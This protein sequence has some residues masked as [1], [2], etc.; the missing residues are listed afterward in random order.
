MKYLNP[1]VIVA[2]LVALSSG[3]AGCD[4]ELASTPKGDAAAER[5]STLPPPDA[6]LL[7]DGQVDEGR[8]PPPPDAAVEAPPAV[9]WV[10]VTLDPRRA[11][12]TRTDQPE[13]SAQAF[14]RTGQPLQV[15]LTWHEAPPG[16]AAVVDGTLQLLQEGQGV[17]Q[18]CAGEVCGQAAFFVDDAPPV[19]VVDSPIQ[20]EVQ[21]GF[22][23]RTI[24]VRGLATDTRGPVAVRVNGLRADVDAEGHFSLDLPADFGLN[25][26][27]IEAD[28]GV[29]SPAV[30]EVR[31]VMWAPRFLPVE[32]DGVAVP[33]A[34]TL[35][36][37]QALLDRDA[38]LDVPEEAGPV[39]LDEVA[40]FLGLLVGLVDGTVL[41]PNPQIANSP[42]FS[43][44]VDAIRLGRPVIDAGF[45]SDGIELFI[46]LPDLT[47]ETRGNIAFE[48]QRFSLDGQITASMAA[49]AHMTVRLEGGALRAEVE[50]VGVTVEGIRGDFDD[51]TAEALVSVLGNQFGAVARDLVTGLV[52]DVVRDS[53]PQ[54][55]QTALGGILGS[56]REVPL[57]IDPRIEGVPP[58]R[59]VLAMEAVNLELARRLA[60]RLTLDA[61]IR[62]AQ[63]AMAL[64]PDPGVPVL[65]ADEE[66][67]IGADGLGVTVRL[68]LVNALLHEVWRGGTLTLRVPVPDNLARLAGETHADALLPPVIVPAPPG[69]PEPL[70]VQFGAMELTMQPDGLSEPHVFQVSLSA[71]LA[72][73]LVDGRFQL[74][75][76][77]VPTVEAVLVHRG[78]GREPT[79]GSDALALVLRTV[80]WPQI[81]GALQGGLD[82]G[83][84]ATSVDVGEFAR[85]APRVQGLTIAPAFAEVPVVRSGRLRLA[86]GLEVTVDLG[87]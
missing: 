47:L 7:P 64:H 86:G 21:S 56:L 34:L 46:G 24:A 19:L 59:L 32:G 78:D 75:V 63:P 61:T 77:E 44:R 6:T 50:E 28:D 13:V 79:L 29:R 35:Q 14:D 1:L 84:D 60:L 38:V 30:R 17:I 41:L 74:G 66:V 62:Q 58:I 26:V 81:R 27:A 68:A 39:A 51:P 33:G 4:D 25:R 15:A 49:F 83:L 20:A 52:E 16:S 42:S 85:Y 23:G 12:Y 67:L 65:S 18:A 70:I 37:D 2:A 36:M 43:L 22:G 80:L 40:S 73:A 45:T 8:P 3:L 87:P 54:L 48:G 31:E 9:A 11:L 53:L 5:D 76:A 55:V 71:G 10:E 69:A 57:N 82:F 72:V